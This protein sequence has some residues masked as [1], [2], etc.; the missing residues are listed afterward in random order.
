MDR[1]RIE[2]AIICSYPRAI[3][4]YQSCN[5]REAAVPG[6]ETVWNIRSGAGYSFQGVVPLKGLGFLVMVTQP[7]NKNLREA[8]LVS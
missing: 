1:S 3:S 4:T 2:S 5:F 7:F 6:R 8:P